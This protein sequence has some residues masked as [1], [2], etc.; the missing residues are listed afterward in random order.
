RVGGRQQI[1]T[2]RYAEAKA[3][4]SAPPK[5]RTKPPLV[6]NIIAT[7]L[8][9]TKV[10]LLWTLPAGKDPLSYHVER[11]VVEVYSEDQIHRLRKDTPPLDEPSVGAI[12]AIGA[13]VRITDVRLEV[14]ELIDTSID[15]T[16]PTALDG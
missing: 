16:R 5:Q 9:P 4:P 11:A 15:L 10:T 12:K 2:Y 8:S 6:E 13:F 3:I 1:W 7:T 14:T